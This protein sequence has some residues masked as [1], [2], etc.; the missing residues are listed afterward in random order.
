[1]T[2]LACVL[3]AGCT[4]GGE[5]PAP[6]PQAAKPTG[7]VTFWHF[8]VDRE[9]NVIQSVIDDFEAKNPGVTVEVK[10]GQDDEKMRQAIAAGQ[11]P[12]VGLSYSTDIVGN[13][14]ETGAWRDL[15]PYVQ[16]DQVDL[17]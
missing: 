7:N 16:R 6:E 13:F 11:G 4:A 8:F 15:A 14:C 9:A 3:A 5:A 17:T 12:D 1:M 10:V 2:V